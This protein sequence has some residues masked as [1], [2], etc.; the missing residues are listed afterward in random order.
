V[1]GDRRL[2]TPRRNPFK[3]S[4]KK[5]GSH[6]GWGGFKAHEPGPN[7]NSALAGGGTGPEAKFDFDAVSAARLAGAVGIQR[8]GGKDAHTDQGEDRC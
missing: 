7:R 5:D 3:R 8:M 1:P 4:P 6:R 2:K